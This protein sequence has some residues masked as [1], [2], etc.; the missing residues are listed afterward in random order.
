MKFKH[1]AAMMTLALTALAGSAMAG[2]IFWTGA[3]NDHDWNNPNN[4]NPIKK[5][6]NFD[7]AYIGSNGPVVIY[8]G[9]SGFANSVHCTIEFDMLGYLFCNGTVE[10]LGR[11]VMAGTMQLNG[12]DIKGQ[13]DFYGGTI[14]PYGKPTTT[15]VFSGAT[16]NVPQSGDATF[17]TYVTV[18]GA[19]TVNNGILRVLGS[20]FYN[21]G[22]AIN[23]GGT[24]TINGNSTIGGNAYSYMAS[25]GQ[26][27][28]S[29][30]QQLPQ[31]DA[32]MAFYNGN[33]AVV[34]VEGGCYAQIWNPAQV[35]YPTGVLHSGYWWVKDNST[36]LF[37]DGRSVSSIQDQGRVI[38]EGPNSVFH[39]LN[40]VNNISS[41]LSLRNGGK[42]IVNEPAGGTLNAP[43]YIDLA[44]GSR[45]HVEGT[46]N[47][48]PTTSITSTLTGMTTGQAGTIYARDS[49]H[50]D[51][52][53][54]AI[55][56]TS[57]KATGS[58]QSV[59]IVETGNGRSSTFANFNG[60]NSP[61]HVSAV[62]DP[63]TA[64]VRLN[65]RADLNGDGQVDDADFVIF[66]FE[67][68][69]LD[70]ASPEMPYGCQADLNYDGVVDDSDFVMF[71]SA[72][73]DLLCP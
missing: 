46:F 50:L 72:Y 73:N 24:C 35:A 43:G 58:D 36:L 1:T 44:P 47:C 70:C 37:P 42:L 6:G 8:G 5:P 16:L 17:N 3:A 10:V 51:G 52:Y 4:W 13:F 20:S 62:Y 65:C 66:V 59:S 38:I 68:N 11:T 67:Y 19:V 40:H 31:I 57:F 22:F 53:F 23:S 39:N 60:S 55:F 25:D 48:T 61:G 49:A 14:S 9:Q 12:L 30:F 63:W 28:F 29:G 45:L 54:L 26:V 18:D 41:S 56:D 7:D 21:G 15:H 64:Q 69:V 2:N 33:Y 32:N 34:R 27:I 71:A